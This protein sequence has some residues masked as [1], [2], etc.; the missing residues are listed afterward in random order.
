VL[1]G[2]RIS[3]RRTIIEI[4]EEEKRKEGSMETIAER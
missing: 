2:A 4:G 3:V 1:R